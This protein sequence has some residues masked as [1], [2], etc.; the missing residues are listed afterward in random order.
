MEADSSKWF[1]HG[2]TASLTL[3]CA[4]ALFGLGSTPADLP[5]GATT[6]VIERLDHLLSAVES[7]DDRQPPRRTPAT[8]MQRDAT[9]PIRGET[10]ALLEEVLAELRA[11]RTEKERAARKERG[12]EVGA[13]HRMLQRQQ[14][15]KTLVNCTTPSSAMGVLGRPMSI[16][17]SGENSEVWKY[18]IGERS[19]TLV[20]TDGRLSKMSY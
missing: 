13:E 14:L 4:W 1:A 6:A 15:A 16:E 8:A 7:I 11:A 5:A 10:V 18:R 3:L 17:A 19:V 20:F 12:Q 2:I 9:S